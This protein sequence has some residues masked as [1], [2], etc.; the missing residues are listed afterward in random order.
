MFGVD[1][2]TIKS[3]LY[4]FEENMKEK[5]DQQI[6]R[7]FLQQHLLIALV[8]KTKQWHFVQD[9]DPKHKSKKSMEL[10]SDLTENRYYKHPPYSPDF[11]EMEDVW[12]YLV[13]I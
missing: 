1:L 10:V 8:T 6:L 7:G 3:K 4:F 12:S 13:L 5:L 11:N 2:G 9:N